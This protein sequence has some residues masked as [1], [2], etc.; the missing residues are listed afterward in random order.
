MILEQ[1]Q[2]VGIGSD[3]TKLKL[4]AIFFDKIYNIDKSIEIPDY[5]SLKSFI[6]VE[7]FTPIS[8]N[9]K[10]KLGTDYKNIFSEKLLP[11]YFKDNETVNR[12]EVIKI[13][14]E[15]G[16][17]TR[18][19]TNNLFSI[20]AARQLSNGKTIGIPIF[21]ETILYDHLE[22]DYINNLSQEKVEIK[23]LN[24]P[25]ISAP[26]LEWTQIVDAKKDP[27]FNS[28]V[29]R[30]GVFINKNY[31]GRELAYIIDDLSLQIEDYKE[32][33]NKHGISLANE[34]FKSLA[35]SKSI[36][37]TMGVALCALL[38]KMPEYAI[39]SSTIGASLELLNLKIT[40]KQYEDKFESF[41][42]ESPISL[43][44]EI[45]KLKSQKRLSQ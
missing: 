41:V 1:Y 37:G 2:T 38:V 40:I 18:N 31:K 33:C 30:F 15:V 42:K 8:E 25:V 27:D 11:K 32:A 6:D 26:D 43:I 45:E 29:K 23:I 20:E 7:K 39:L 21:N 28:K 44:F 17:E 3:E 10:L 16:S 34:T 9:L 36:F 4:A 14:T 19:K 24:A 22:N 35:N 13:L 12:D 5:L